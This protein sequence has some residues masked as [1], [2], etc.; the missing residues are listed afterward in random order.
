[1]TENR[2]TIVISQPMLMPWRGMFEQI[3]LSDIFVFYDDVQLP[4]GGG[5]GR[6]FITRIQIKAADGFRWLSLPVRRSHQGKQLIADAVFAHH[7]WRQ[8][9][10]ESI[11][12]CYRQAPFFERTYESVVRPIYELQTDSVSEFC[13]NSTAVLAKELGL[14]R[15][16]HISSRI[17]K[18][19]H[20]D[21]SARILELCRL[22][23]ADRY[24]SGLGAMNYINYDLFEQARVA[25][26]YM[27]YKLSPYPQLHGPFNPYVSVIDLLFN[28]GEDAPDCLDSGAVYWKDY[29]NLLQAR[30]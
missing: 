15:D 26:A 8:Q 21:A 4:M 12:Q 10:L 11:R 18:S 1:M 28:A 9:H 17:P 2:K 30:T 3:K 6:G 5:K 24:V 7:D 13:M 16:W 19:S 25:V 14:N 27:A 29:L 23:G 22:F 20:E